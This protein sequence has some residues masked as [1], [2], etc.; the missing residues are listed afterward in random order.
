MGRRPRR[1]ARRD[2]PGGSPR[3]DRAAADDDCAAAAQVEGEGVGRRGHQM[4]SPALRSGASA[5]P[6]ARV[7]P[8]D[9]SIEQEGA[10]AAQDAVVVD[11]HLLGEPQPQSSDRVEGQALWRRQALHGLDVELVDEVGH[12]GPDGAGADAHEDAGRGRAA[13]GRTGPPRCP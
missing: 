3:R 10:G 1:G 9:S 8:S 11:R 6:A 12:H 13:F 2:E 7:V 5:M 4:P